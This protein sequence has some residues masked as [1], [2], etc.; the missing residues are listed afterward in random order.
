MRRFVLI[1]SLFCA[2]LVFSQQTVDKVKYFGSQN[3]VEVSPKKVQI[4]NGV[5]KSWSYQ[6]TPPT[7]AQLDAITQA[8]IDSWQ[9]DSRPTRSFEQIFTNRFAVMQGYMGTNLSVSI[10]FSV[11]DSLIIES[12]LNNY[13]LNIANASEARAVNALATSLLFLWNHITVIDPTA[14]YTPYFGQ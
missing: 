6:E 10:P 3:G 9:I 5:F 8:D 7:Q 13:A 1:V 4:H 11:G 12:E 2:S 14:M